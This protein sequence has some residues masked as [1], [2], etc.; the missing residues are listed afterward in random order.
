[1]AI[2]KIIHYCWFGGGSYSSLIKRC[3]ESWHRFCPDYQFICWNETNSPIHDNDYVSQAF[4][5]RKWAFVSDYV[6]LTALYSCGG[7]YLD[8]DVELKA[9]LDP[10]LKYRAFMGFESD[11]G[12]AT[13][14]IGAEPQHSFIGEAAHSYDGRNFLKDDGSFDMT[15]NV[16]TITDLLCRAGLRRDGS[17]QQVADAEIFPA[18]FFSPKSPE[19]VRT[20]YTSNTVSVHHFNGTWLS[21]SQKR[22]MKIARI[23]GTRMTKMIKDIKN[24]ER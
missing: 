4:K 18:D 13:C 14:I 24:H 3:M 9:P 20:R 23:L 6:R 22:N 8:T 15:T 19:T 7:I 21:A 12:I 2:P 11:N 10:F 1:M 5:S 16:Q 17:R